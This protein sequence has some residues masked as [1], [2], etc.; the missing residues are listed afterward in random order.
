LEVVSGPE[1]WTSEQW[2]WP[3]NKSLESDYFKMAYSGTYSV[4]VR[5]EHD[6]KIAMK[7]GSWLTIEPTAWPSLPAGT[8]T[9]Q[10]TCSGYPLWDGVSP[11]FTVTKP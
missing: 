2:N 4:R 10:A 11:T 6:G 1:T 8:Y 5:I 3:Y 9:F 7:E